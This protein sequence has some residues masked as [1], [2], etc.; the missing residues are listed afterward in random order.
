MVLLLL[1]VLLPLAAVTTPAAAAVVVVEVAL[2]AASGVGEVE[3]GP[4][5][6]GARVTTA[7][8]YVKAKAL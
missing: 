3:E 1:V 8:L 4:W 2:I 7:Y 5:G 6:F